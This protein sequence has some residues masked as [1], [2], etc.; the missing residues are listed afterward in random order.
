MNIKQSDSRAEDEFTNH[1]EECAVVFTC[2]S[3]EMILYAQKKQR[4]NFS[5][6]VH[7]CSVNVS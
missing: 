7:S 5:V 4:K 2:F 6:L 3:H 1:K